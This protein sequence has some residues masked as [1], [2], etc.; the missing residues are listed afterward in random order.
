MPRRFERHRRGTQ[1]WD[2]QPARSAE[3]RT[4]TA[5]DPDPAKRAPAKKDTRHFCKGKPG[6]E[7]VPA[8][9]QDE[10]APGWLKAGCGWR[11]DWR[12][13]LR[14]YDAGWHC[15]HREICTGCGKILREGW[16]VGRECP[17]YPG[18]PDQRV[19]A[20]AEAARLEARHEEWAGR[21]RPVITGP[22][23][24]RRQR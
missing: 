16:D 8:I 1:Y 18:D 10:R 6:V 22:Q 4:D 13:R 19:A 9:V 15:Q 12:V 24:Y 14:G 11:A 20:V 2:S 3:V 17:D 21:R 7:H 23:G 5:R